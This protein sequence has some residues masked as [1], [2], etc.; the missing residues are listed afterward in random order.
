[1]PLRPFLPAALLGLG[2]ALPAAAIED[3]PAVAFER[4][5]GRL[6][7]RIDGRPYA[8]YVFDDARITRPYFQDLHA[9]GGLRLTRRNPPVEGEDLTDHPTFHPG[10]WMAFG[11]L[12]GADSWRNAEPVRHA[13]FVEEPRPIPGG[14]TFAVR[15][16]Y[17]KGGRPIAEEL[18]RFTIRPSA[19]A[20]LLIW[21]STFRPL[22]A[23]LAF[24]DQE[25]M[26][27]AVRMHTPLAVVRGGRIA[28]GEGRRNE[29]EVWG[30][31]AAWCA[32]S[33]TLDGERIGVVLMPDPG[34][35][36]PCWYHARDYGLLAANPFGRHAL[37]G[38]EPGRVE[39]P[40]GQTLRL[41]FGVWTFRGPLDPA[42]GY[43]AFLR[44]GKD[45]AGSN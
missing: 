45:E 13:G 18:A 40:P 19:D 12:D 38:G 6:D 34:N 43:R 10:L 7:I 5:P 36:R 14:A 39:V 28:D 30:K 42:G 16:R 44:H 35:F 9:P 21:D 1:M 29:P 11:D 26:G 41:R 2:L 24:G 33:G 15:N 3:E 17:L 37:T 22:D 20:T 32:Y 31:S 8:A 23:P 25:E 27:L 4:R